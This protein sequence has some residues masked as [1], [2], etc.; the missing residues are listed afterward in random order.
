MDWISHGP[1]H[2]V[3]A[4]RYLASKMLVASQDTTL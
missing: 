1:E 3:V 2:R 4:L